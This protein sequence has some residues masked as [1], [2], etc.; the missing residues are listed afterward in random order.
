MISDPGICQIKTVDPWRRNLPTLAHPFEYKRVR[1]Y[2]LK[3]FFPKI[4]FSINDVSETSNRKKLGKTAYLRVNVVMLSWKSLTI[5]MT[6]REKNTKKYW[7][8]CLSHDQIDCSNTKEL[9]PASFGTR[10]C[11]GNIC[12]VLPFIVLPCVLP[13]LRPYEISSFKKP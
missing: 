13:S 5:L 2:A 6:I 9:R 8:R 12:L 1:D 10:L 11:S 4:Y 3:T 7:G